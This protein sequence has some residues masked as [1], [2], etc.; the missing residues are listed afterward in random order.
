MSFSGSLD[1]NI[2]LRFILGDVEGHYQAASD[3]LKRS[4]K[5]LAVADMAFVEVVFVMEKGYAM[6][7]R[8]IAVAL[9]SII[10]ISVINCN[11]SL[12]IKVIPEYLEKPALSFVDC[13]LAVY[14]ELGGAEPLYT[15]DKKLANQLPNIK[16]LV[17]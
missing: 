1:A 9:E 16:L 17:G 2:L 6:S 7:R 10:N 3:L 12:L 11:R 8:D 15:F 4:E 14:A 13:C 5:Q